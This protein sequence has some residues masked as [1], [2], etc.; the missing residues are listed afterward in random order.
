M[1][2]VALG[3]PCPV[4]PAATRSALALAE[5]RKEIDMT[6]G[7]RVDDVAAGTGTNL[8]LGR[9]CAGGTGSWAPPRTASMDDYSGNS[10]TSFWH[11]NPAP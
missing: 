2:R 7:R 10:R 8:A 3:H 1:P 6:S 5:D 9:D 4:A 11:S